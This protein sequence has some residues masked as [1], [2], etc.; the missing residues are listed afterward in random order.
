MK[1]QMTEDIVSSPDFSDNEGKEEASLY[2]IQKL[3]DTDSEGLVA[4]W[5]RKI[6]KLSPFSTMV[7][8]LSSLAFYSYRIFCI[9]EAQRIY[10]KPYI[11]AWVFVFT[12]ACLLCESNCLTTKTF[13]S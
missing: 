4:A 6:Y 3:H 11:V 1:E 2:S 9:V 13:L 8:I 5:K 12:E 7:S 10:H